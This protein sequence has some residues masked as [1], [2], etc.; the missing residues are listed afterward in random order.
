[1]QPALVRVG[2]AAQM[3]AVS[4]S[5]IRRLVASGRLEG[6]R[7]LPDVPGSS[8]R[9]RRLDVERLTTGTP[10]GSEL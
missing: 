1:M 6:V 10:I 3:L 5:T 2:E 7:L 9:L 8:V 4:P